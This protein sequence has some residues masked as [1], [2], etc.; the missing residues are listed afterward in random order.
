MAVSALDTS[1]VIYLRHSAAGVSKAGFDTT[2]SAEDT[3]RLAA[4]QLE[5]LADGL[6]RAFEATRENPFLLE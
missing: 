4:S 3:L 6:Q 2:G 1:D 5:W